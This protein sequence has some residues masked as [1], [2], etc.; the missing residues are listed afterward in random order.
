MAPCGIHGADHEGQPCGLCCPVCKLALD[1]RSVPCPKPPGTC[2]LAH[3]VK[4]C[5]A[6]HTWAGQGF[7]GPIQIA[8]VEATSEGR[9]VRAKVQSAS[10]LW[11]ARGFLIDKQFRFN[12]AEIPGT[13]FTTTNPTLL[14]DTT[15]GTL[16]V[17]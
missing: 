15:D 7:T 4:V 16:E 1:R 10:R 11:Q 14:L 17:A 6:G 8:I 5:V 2:G 3:F 12:P 13:W 9:P